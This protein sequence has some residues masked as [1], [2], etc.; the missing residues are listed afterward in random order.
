MNKKRYAPFEEK[1]LA[2]LERLDV[3]DSAPE[4]EFDA[5]VKAAALVCGTPISLITLLSRDRQWFKAN[6]GL[7]D[8][9]EVDREL[10]FCTYAI[11]DT[12]LME[13]QDAT[14]DPRFSDN[15]FV[16]GDSNIRFYA[17]VP[18][19]LSGG[20]RV[21]TLC[22][23]DRKIK[24]LREDQKEIL[25]NLAR[26]A[27]RALEMRRA[28]IH[29]SELLAIASQSQS[30]LEY[31]DD[32]ILTMDWAGHVQQWNRAAE[33]MFGYT[34]EEM[35]GNSF[36]HIIKDAERVTELD[37][38][39]RLGDGQETRSINT[40]R[41]RKDGS[42]ISVS[43]SVGPV[44]SED[45]EVVGATEIIRDISDI[46]RAY[47][48]LSEAEQRVSRLY[49]STP[50]MLHSVDPNGR[51]LS[52][53]DR[54][55]EVMG[56]T[57]EDVVGRPLHEFMTASSALRAISKVMPEFLKTGH[58]ENI[59]YQFVT[60]NG[61][62]ID[63]L[64]SAILERD[65]SGT[66]R[67][68][69]G[70]V[71]NITYRR[72]VEKALRD[73]RSR[74]TQI[75]EGTRAGTWEWNLE[76]GENRVNARWAE[77][78]GY[79]AEE[80]LPVQIETFR[81]LIHPGDRAATNAR[82]EAHFKGELDAYETEMRLRH[83][84]G[85]WIWVIS[86]G[87][88]LTWTDNGR[89][90]WMFGTHQD[91]TQRKN[92]EEERLLMGERM[93]IAADSAGVGIW[94]VDLQRKQVTWDRW[95]Y[96]LY[97]LSE[98]ADEPIVELWRH[99]VHPHD[100][101]RVTAAVGKA[102]EQ[103]TPMEEEYRI[104][105]PD[106]SVHHLHVSARVVASDGGLSQR[107][108]GAAWD[109]TEERQM[110]IELAEQHELMRV[111]LTSIG[112]AVITADAD[113]RIQWLNPVAEYM[114]GWSASKAKGVVS[115]EVF[116]I[117]HEETRDRARDPIQTCLE[118]GQAAGLPGDT[119]LLALDGRE[120]GIEDS[121]API[122]SVEGELLGA[123]L[124]FHDVSE[125][126]RHV[127]E[128]SY[129]A[130]HDQLTG[131]VNRS[132]FERR[133]NRL[134]E[135]AKVDRSENA[136]LYIDLDQFKIV[137]DS[138]GHA[139]GDEL[140]KKVSQLM[141]GIIRSGDTLARLGGDEF[142]VILEHCPMGYAASIAQSICDEMNDFRF[143]HDGKQFR[144]GTSIGLVPVDETATSISSLLQ[145]ADSSCYVAKE[146]GRNRVHMWRDDD[147]AHNARLGET[148]WVSRIEEALDKNSFILYAQKIEPLSAS[149][150]GRHLEL[151]LRMLD[152]DGNIIMPNAFLPAA[153]RFNLVGRIDRWVLSNAIRWMR[154]S[155]IEKN[156]VVAINLSGQS[157][158]DRAFHKFAYEMMEQAGEVLCHNLCFE[159]TE[160]AVISNI[161]EAVEFID[162]ARSHGI[163]IALDDFGAGTT[164][165]SYLKRFT[166]DYLKID[167][168][169]T[170]G[171]LD[172]EPIDEASI[173]CFANMARVLGAKT[174]AEFVSDE[175]LLQKLG[176]LDIDLAQGY[177]V[178][179]PQPAD[180]AI[181]RS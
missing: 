23:L 106:Q 132:E 30:I 39:T 145:A 58:C 66:P 113:G 43:V 79:E 90:E 164:S 99:A 42:C 126:R 135:K 16:T 59:P 165:F 156:D 150:G 38:E 123:V 133:L 153:E 70:I 50:A 178:H 117:V 101:D 26:A 108:I 48:E 142:A 41:V 163:A 19:V 177:A 155:G 34:A 80:L 8:L 116:R 83:K 68:T 103:T 28:A 122:R 114:T 52:V 14:S 161:A 180:E 22:V 176:E 94:E 157:V 112:D 173:R 119:I 170:Q 21:G 7:D 159:I 85:H 5:L 128:M 139:V 125:Q 92:E 3:L 71:E 149:S 81:D 148:R 64:L 18:L 166:I 160:T 96:R 67:R 37:L 111:T 17:G 167:G 84:E 46:S 105:W 121:A 171:L 20:E 98:K 86:R 102:M 54:W 63:V 89:P 33:R 65:S 49:R 74:L 2:A 131:L 1:R 143:L 27:A 29:E 36:G 56:Y 127:R 25:R 134:Y 97:G 107:L 120:F 40:E 174:I 76:T 51:L 172:G 146:E 130:S 109:V 62:I 124:V 53:S 129:R 151:L 44:V 104:I 6:I 45:G 55:L 77:M 88:V 15:P 136:L 100:L 73:E 87:Q 82:L 138:C 11:E 169:F 31:S 35:I 140:L 69:I 158:G 78:L 115:H 162:V 147:E 10:S 152:E 141:Q 4:Q 47:S 175:Q 110:S 75:I 95:M 13:V 154:T 144:I 137:N 72:Q 57:R 118:L 60:N 179:F 12:K 32:A 181:E 9:Q 93:A 24:A 91:V 61:S 168:Q